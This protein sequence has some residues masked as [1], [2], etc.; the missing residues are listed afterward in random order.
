MTEVGV[1]FV[2]LVPSMRGFQGAASRALS[3]GLRGPLKKAGDDAGDALGKGIGDGVDKKRGLLSGVSDG[4]GDLFKTGLAGAGLAAGAA[5]A[6]GIQGALDKEVQLD[7][8]E[9][10]LGGGEFAADMGKIA[11]NLYMDAFGESIADTGDAVRQVL[12]AGLLPEDATNA[13]IESMT[14]KVLTFSDVM[15]QDLG[16]STQAVSNIIQNGLAPN[17]EAA[18]DVLTKG[19]Q[20][21]ADQAG[22]LLETF[23]EYP[24]NFR[25]LGLSAEDA[26]G[27]LV[28]GLNAGARDS[29]KVADALKE[30]GIRGQDMSDTSREAFET[31]GLNAD[32]MFAKFAAGGPEARGALDQVLDG[33]QE[34][35]DPALRNAAA[36]ALFGSQAEDLGDALFGLDLDT[37]A[38]G[39]GEVEGSTDA[40]G[41]AYDNA[42]TKIEAFKRQ[43]MDKLITFVG[44][45][46]LPGLERLAEVVGPVLSAAWDGLKQVMGDI[47]WDGISSA[48]STVGENISMFF[49]SL[50]TGFTKDEGTGIENLA[51]NLRGFIGFL[52]GEA[53][54]VVQQVLTAMTQAWRE[55]GPAV[56][57]VLTQLASIV[58]DVINLIIVIIRGAVAVITFIWTNWGDEI[59]G[60][61]S[62]IWELISGVISGALDV[63]QGIIRTVTALITG[64]WEGAWEGI[65]QILSGVWEIMATIVEA[66]WDGIVAILDLGFAVLAELF[67][68][69][70]DGIK[71]IVEE[72]WEL[73]K[74]TTEAQMNA[75]IDFLSGAWD[76][77]KSTASDAWDRLKDLV[78][79]AID[80][81]VDF[82]ADLPGR[83][84][85]G[86]SSLA[87]TLTAP[88][89][90]AFNAIKRL[91]NNTLGGFSVDIPGIGG[92][93]GVSFS[94]PRMHTGGIVPTR[95]GEVPIMARAGEGVF[96]TQQMAALAPVSDLEGTAPD[97]QVNVVLGAGDR[98]LMRWLR[99]QVRV[100]GGGDVQ[101][102]FGVT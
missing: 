97:Q 68:A 22:D 64:D 63:I 9:A 77:V 94:I 30:I 79:D 18:F 62:V 102:A 88:F 10:Q 37:A 58:G 80:K 69:A 28:Q 71:A 17:A 90:S 46:V 67:S 7:K 78:E 31:L 44:N 21:G 5:L 83:L 45:T 59:L 98:D 96:T 38:S 27:L 14:A 3:D 41:S 12:N 73:L 66:A 52:R 11:G 42:S 60:V 101:R 25:E 86:L 76:T 56:M 1:G 20:L 48:I 24:T 65:K 50:R 55:H 53:W 15:E 70:W 51:L 40:L 99:K 33:L 93:G 57:E 32:E 84:R 91:W 23:Q 61:L 87:R 100:A 34:I 82:V 35:E 74:A 43:A 47:D 6:V 16:L 81:I 39:L 36:V 75:I 13:Q 54:P 4:I 2:Q 29:D 49:N 26:M 85:R 19:A 95:P 89:R 72:A 92:F 8:L